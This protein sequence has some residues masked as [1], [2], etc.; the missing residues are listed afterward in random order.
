MDDFL[1]IYQASKLKQDWINRLI[2]PIN[3]KEI[4][5]VI[6]ILTTK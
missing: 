5:A 3:H 1:D 2:N 6:R 4:E